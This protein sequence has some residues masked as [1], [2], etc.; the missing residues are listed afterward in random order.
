[1]ELGKRRIS[2]DA[3]K[4]QQVTCSKDV[5]DLMSVHLL[6]QPYEYVWAVFL[7]RKNKILHKELIGTGGITGA[8]LDANRLLRTALE[9]YATGIILCH[10]HPSGNLIP[11]QEDIQMTQKITEAATL[12]NIRVL[13]HLIVGE[14]GYYS[15]ADENLIN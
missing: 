15:F 2:C 14:N 5:Y 10:N 8:V 3:S 6:D 11:S 12:L 1:L 9:V 7:D 13:D 4:K